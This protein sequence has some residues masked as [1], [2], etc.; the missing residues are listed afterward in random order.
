MAKIL[1]VEDEPDIRADLIEELADAGHT[2]ASAENG[3]EGLRRA[4]EFRPDVILCDCLMPTMTGVELLRELRQRYPEFAATPFV[5]LSAYSDHKY[6]H[7]A[8][9]AGAYSYLTKPVDY[10]QLESVLNSALGQSGAAPAP[11]QES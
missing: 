5:V 8:M 4:V 11:D 3:E 1:C 2:V 9:S 6:S 7:E 10:D